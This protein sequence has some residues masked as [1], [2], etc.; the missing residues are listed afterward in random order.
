MQAEVVDGAARGA[1]LL[2]EE[3]LSYWGGVRLETGKIVDR[4][5]PQVG[6]STKLPAYL[7]TATDGGKSVFPDRQLGQPERLG[8]VGRPPIR[9]RS[10]ALSAEALPTA[11]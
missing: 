1:A 4:H 11:R 9:W 5:H 3:P 8:L 7:C 2:L 6:G 10:A